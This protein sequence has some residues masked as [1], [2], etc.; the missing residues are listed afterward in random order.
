MCKRHEK[1]L[2]VKEVHEFGVHLFVAER[3]GQ[4]IIY[5]PISHEGNEMALDF[6]IMEYNKR[7]K[8]LVCGHCGMEFPK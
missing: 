2:K 6:Y 8:V 3:E 1:R 7:K 5:C 4:K